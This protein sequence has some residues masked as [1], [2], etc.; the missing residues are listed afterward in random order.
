MMTLVAVA[1]LAINLHGASAAQCACARGNVHVRSGAGTSHAVLGTLISGSCVTYEGDQSSGWV[2]V[3]YNG[4]SGWIAGN[5]VNIQ[6]CSGG[7]VTSGGG[8]LDCSGG[9]RYSARGTAYYPADNPLEGG[10]V[11]MRGARLRTLQ[12]FL[13]GS[14]S[15]VSVAMDNHA[16]I[17]YGTSICIPEMNQRYNKHIVFKVVDTGSAFFGKGHSRIDIC[18]S[19]QANSY[20]STIN[21]HLTLVFP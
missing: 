2:H 13:A 14:A 4:R 19:S 21:G 7:S 18:V 1:A 10:F 15:Y 20:D 16:G 9:H 17:A 5:Y 12:Q 6:T 8:G 11:D 3:D